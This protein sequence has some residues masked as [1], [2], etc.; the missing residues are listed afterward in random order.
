ME[1]T[2]TFSK[3]TLSRYIERNRYLASLELNELMEQEES[4]K[5]FSVEQLGMI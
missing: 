3:E 1:T 2:T 4:Y 5:S